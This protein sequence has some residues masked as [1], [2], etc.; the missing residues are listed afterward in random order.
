LRTTN[1][2]I[3]LND[4]NAK[5]KDRAQGSVDTISHHNLPFSYLQNE[6]GAATTVTSPIH[7]NS[8]RAL[9]EKIS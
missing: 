7:H 1:S 6:I 2:S 3:G 9:I 8:A 5:L 4:K